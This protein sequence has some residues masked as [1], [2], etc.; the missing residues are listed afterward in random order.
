MDEPTAH[1]DFGNQIQVL[2]LIRQMAETGLVVI[3][4]S[5]APDHAIMTA[6]KV[7]LMT[8]G[9]VCIGP[10]ETILTEDR[11]QAVYGVDIRIM[12][13]GRGGKTCIPLMARRFNR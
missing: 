2:T 5:H 7:A 12:D 11:L 4:T 1:L 3:M 8:D 9:E 6:K 13:N 10:P